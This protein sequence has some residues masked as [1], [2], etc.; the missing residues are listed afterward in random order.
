MGLGMLVETTTLHDALRQQGAPTAACYSGFSLGGFL[1]AFIT[2]MAGQPDIT[3]APCMAG[4]SANLPFT[5]GAMS[6]CVDWAA[7]EREQT[8]ITEF[9]LDLQATPGGDQLHRWTPDELRSPVA[10]L[11]AL[12]DTF[13]DLA[14]LPPLEDV[15]HFVLLA[16]DRDAYIP[17]ET[18]RQLAELWSGADARVLDGHGHVT[19]FFLQ[20]AAMREAIA[21]AA[22]RLL[23]SLEQAPQQDRKAWA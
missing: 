7:L 9:L 16:A 3:C 18:H 20:Q 6:T 21:D 11:G 17:Y 14:Q 2:A 15:S 23:A 8:I 4:R 10:V 1:A 19:S 12:L 22:T 5:K 13:T